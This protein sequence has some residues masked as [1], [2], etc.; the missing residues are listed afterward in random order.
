MSVAAVE[1]LLG[2]VWAEIQ[3]EQR[4][5]EAERAREDPVAYKLTTVF[6]TGSSLNYRFWS[7]KVR[8]RS[9]R[10]AYCTER[11][12]AGYFLCWRETINKKGGGKR[13]LWR[14]SKRRKMVREWSL[15][16]Y[17]AHKAKLEK[18]A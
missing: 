2:R 10:Y 13:D 17:K 8:G 16:R 14:A 1:A 7:V 9:V 15:Q 11:N 5:Y 12:A 4:S 18:A 3:A 6:P